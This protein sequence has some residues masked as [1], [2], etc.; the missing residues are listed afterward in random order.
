MIPSTG[1]PHT[2][3]VDFD[4]TLAHYD[5]WRGAGV[6][7]EPIPEMLERVKRWLA[8][9]VKVVI[10]TARVQYDPVPLDRTHPEFEYRCAR[11]GQA[12]EARRAIRAWC[13]KHLGTILEVTCEKRPEYEAMWDDRAVPVIS[14]TGKIGIR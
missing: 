6:L 4:G 7:G 10:F 14:N 8:E 11:R 5:G 1:K 3:A 9:G 13:E 12:Q 2:I